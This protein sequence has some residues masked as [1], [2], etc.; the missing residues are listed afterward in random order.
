MEK[1]FLEKETWFQND[2]RHSKYRALPK[3]KN[4]NNLFSNEENLED[5]NFF[6]ASENNLKGGSIKMIRGSIKMK[7]NITNN[8]TNYLINKKERKKEDPPQLSFEKINLKN[9]ENIFEQKNKIY[10]K[11]NS[12]D[13]LIEKYTQNENLRFELKE[14]LKTRKL[15]KA[16]LSNHALELSFRKLD[17]LSNSDDE[18]IEI[19]QESIMNSWIGFFP[20]K[21]YEKIQKRPS[22]VSQN[23]S[24]NIDEYESSMDVF[25]SND[26]SNPVDEFNP[27]DEIRK[28]QKQVDPSFEKF[29]AEIKDDAIKRFGPRLG[30]KILKIK[31]REEF[32]ETVD[33]LKDMI[34]RKYYVW[35][36]GDYVCAADIEEKEE[37]KENLN[38]FGTSDSPQIEPVFDF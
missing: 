3:Y 28:K 30:N 19:V 15:K 16:A 21:P 2:E 18:K 35:F 6:C 13:A 11:E 20:L 25:A 24:Y 9:E 31:E 22:S 32:W 38:F 17:L 33:T 37:E 4:N 5:E 10:E 8:K 36:N 1:G 14:H 34:K 23:T 27:M 12:F 7:H 26:E 29:K